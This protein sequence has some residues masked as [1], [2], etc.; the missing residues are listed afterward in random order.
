M[1]NQ[2]KRTTKKDNAFF[3]ALSLYPNVSRASKTAGYNRERVYVWRKQDQKFYDRWDEAWN[4]A[5]EAM[6]EEL[7]RRALEGVEE[8]VFQGGEEVGTKQKFS[9]TL[10]IF[11][12]KGARPKKYREHQVH[13]HTA[14]GGGP[15]LFQVTM[16][17]AE[18]SE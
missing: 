7:M 1:A 12:M 18:Q 15:P 2:T 16:V 4:L 11:M 8:P 5:I 6:E 10:G 17:K 14:P 9:D 3:K 13:E